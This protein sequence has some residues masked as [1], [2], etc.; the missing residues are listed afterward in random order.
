MRPVFQLAFP[1]GDS[2]VEIPLKLFLRGVPGPIESSPP[3]S[4]LMGAAVGRSPQRVFP[5]TV[6]APIAGARKTRFGRSRSG[7]ACPLDGNC[8]FARLVVRLEVDGE[9]VRIVGGVVGTVQF[10]RLRRGEVEERS[11]S[12]GLVLGS[13][14]RLDG[15]WGAICGVS[16]SILTANPFAS[17]T[18]ACECAGVSPIS[19]FTGVSIS[20]VNKMSSKVCV[21]RIASRG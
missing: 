16:V 7:I 11:R 6:A 9:G 17:S 20:S 1:K 13:D 18:V 5:A 8:Q 2:P 21:P 15:G 19:T 14:L 10:E 12:V 3:S 4:E